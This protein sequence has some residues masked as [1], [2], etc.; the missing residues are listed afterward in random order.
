MCAAQLLRCASI[1]CIPAFHPAG[2]TQWA[3]PQFARTCIAQ[4]VGVALL[5]QC[6]VCLFDLRVTGIIVHLEG[7]GQYAGVCGMSAGEGQASTAQEAWGLGA[8]AVVNR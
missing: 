4:V 7:G 1:L 3:R 5:G 2:P 6:T 8:A